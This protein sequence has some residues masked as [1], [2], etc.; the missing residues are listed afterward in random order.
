MSLIFD[1]WRRHY[2]WWGEVAC[3][4]WE[5][6]NF[7]CGSKSRIHVSSMAT[8]LFKN[9]SPSALWRRSSSSATLLR[10]AFCSS[11]SWCGTHFAATFLFCNVW[12][13]IM[14]TE[15]V[16]MFASCAVSLND[17][18]RSPS[19]RVLTI[20]TDVSSVAFYWPP[21]SWVVLDAYPTFTKTRFPPWHR[22]TIHYQFPQTSCK[23]L[24]ISI[25]FFL[26]KF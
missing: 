8:N 17:L 20:T 18:R 12:V 4:H 7:S 14:K 13:T 6:W 10:A 5:D 25:G 23:A 24:W 16:D 21:T 1:C 11:L 19:N 26:A 9:C 3:F 2:F 22:A 15:A